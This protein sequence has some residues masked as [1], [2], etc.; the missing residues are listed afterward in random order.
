MRFHNLTGIGIE[1]ETTGQIYNHKQ[2]I[3]NLLNELNN[4]NETNKKRYWDLRMLILDADNINE[5]RT[6]IYKEV[7]D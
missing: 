6:R 3:T 5:L 4:E 2:D 1:D 7:T